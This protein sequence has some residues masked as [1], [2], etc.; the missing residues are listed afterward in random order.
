MISV[1]PRGPGCRVCHWFA[2]FGCAHISQ[3]DNNKYLYPYPETLLCAW[4]KNFLNGW[5]IVVCDRTT[6]T[7]LQS[8]TPPFVSFSRLKDL[9]NTCAEQHTDCSLPRQDHA[10]PHLR[11]INCTTREVVNAPINCEYVALSYVWGSVQSVNDDLASMQIVPL[12]I[13]QSIAV[14]SKLGFKFLWVDRYVSQPTRFLL[15][16]ISQVH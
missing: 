6:Q 10:I 15:L 2:E 8:L 4:D 11:V 5:K 9:L 1:T 14:A 16:L 12:V 7:A 13:E 3:Y